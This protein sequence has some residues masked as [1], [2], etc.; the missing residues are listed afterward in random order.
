MTFCWLDQLGKTV[1]KGCTFSFVFYGKQNKKSLGKRPRFSK[2]LSNA[3]AFTC[4][5]GNAGL[6][7]RENRLYV[8]SQPPR[9]TSKLESFWELQ[10]SAESRSLT[11]PSWLNPSMKPQSGE[12]RSL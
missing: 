1:W 10:V 3:S 5:R 12:N 11:T 4:S 7:L 9:L 8:P 6:A 2:M